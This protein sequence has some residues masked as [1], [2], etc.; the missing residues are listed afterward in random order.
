M[1]IVGL[2]GGIGS[3]K[4]TVIKRF[5]ELGVP[6]I[7]ADEIAHD[8]VRPG[9][10]ALQTIIDEFGSGLLTAQGELDRTQLRRIVFTD[11]ARRKMLE[12]I[13]H[14]LIRTEML[15][16]A[17]E[18]KFSYCV[19]CIP[20]LVETHQTGMVDRVLVIDSPEKLQ[21]Q[22]IKRRD[23]LP[24]TEIKAILAAQAT[25]EDRLTVA[26][27]VIVNDRSLDDI[28]RQVDELHQKYLKLAG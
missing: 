13:L 6:V 15:R 27:D 4:S 25:P 28:Y 14:P 21:A 10:P 1:M 26:D 3:G 11:P 18:I 16:R 12:S 19:F 8:L 7:D 9:Q 5:V 17:D 20:L 24:D 2:T 23:G 22:R